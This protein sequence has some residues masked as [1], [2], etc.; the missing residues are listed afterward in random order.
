MSMVKFRPQLVSLSVVYHLYERGPCQLF[1]SMSDHRVSHFMAQNHLWG[2]KYI[3]DCSGKK[4]SGIAKFIQ[5][6]SHRKLV[7][8]FTEV[9][10]SRKDK[11]VSTWKNEGI[12]GRL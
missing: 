7:V 8:V 12:L 11:N 3:S 5:V 1:C 6:G 10:H 9:E 2:S 4:Y